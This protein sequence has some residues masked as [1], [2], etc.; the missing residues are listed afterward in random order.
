LNWLCNIEKFGSNTALY[1]EDGRSF[2]YNEIANLSEDRTVSLRQ[3]DLVALECDNSL[4]SVLA[5][6]GLINRKI[7]ILLLDRNLAGDLKKLILEHYRVSVVVCSG[8]CERILPSGPPMHSELGLM[9]STSGSTGSPKL[10]RLTIDNLISNAK[11][12]IEYLHLNQESRAITV[13][14]LQY[15]FGL[16]I[17]NSHLL[18]GGSLVLTNKSIAERFFWDLLQST[19]TNSFSGVPATF[20][21]LRRMRFERMNLPN[22]KTVTQAGGRLSAESVRF[23]TELGR[24]RGFEFFVMYGQTEA[25]ARMAYLPPPQALVRSDSIGVP[26]PGGRFELIDADGKIID[27]DYVQGELVYYG[28]NVMM[29]YASCVE[30]LAK[31]DENQGVLKTGDIAERDS[32][33][34]YYIRG[35]LKRFIKIFGNRVNLDEVEKHLQGIGLSVYTSGKDDLMIIFGTDEHDV[36]VSAV[37]FCKRYQFHNSSVRTCVVE[38]VPRNESGKVQY[39][40]LLEIFEDRSV[41]AP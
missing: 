28:P 10:V 5:Y 9:L 41:V 40:Q 15:S 30:D 37:E 18:I 21:M 2:S 20:E 6:I 17:V 38:S 16:S 23:F 25:T 29:G 36:Q 1:I 7:P 11:Q 24:A 31:G 13:L 3:G 27:Q 19:N 34:F 22:L 39:G 35:R 4:D 26:I 12:I 14:P 8:R 32:E 33:G